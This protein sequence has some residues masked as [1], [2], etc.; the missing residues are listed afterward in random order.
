MAGS[1]PEHQKPNQS[2]NR[3]NK[4]VV[5]VKTKGREGVEKDIIDVEEVQ[6]VKR[7]LR[8]LPRLIEDATY[9]EADMLRESVTRLCSEKVTLI[10]RI[11]TLLRESSTAALREA[12]LIERVAELETPA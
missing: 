7:K 9:V 1:R 5:K 11:T 4:K 3:V 8:K 2:D 12:A 6:I 10:N